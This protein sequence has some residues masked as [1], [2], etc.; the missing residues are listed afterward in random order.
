MQLLCI[1]VPRASDRRA[2]MIEQFRRLGMAFEIFSATDWQN[3]D[4]AD[5]AQVD[6][7]T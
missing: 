3:L 7:E 2:A 4:E 6:A 1:N 5:F